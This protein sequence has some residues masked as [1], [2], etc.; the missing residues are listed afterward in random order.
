MYGPICW[1]WGYENGIG[2]TQNYFSLFFLGLLFF[3][4]IL[5]LSAT[6]WPAGLW[7]H[8]PH[9]VTNCSPTHFAAI[10]N[11]F[12]ICDIEHVDLE[13]HSKGSFFPE[14]ANFR[15]RHQHDLLIM[16]KKTIRI[17]TIFELCRVL[18][19]ISER[20]REV[21]EIQE[22]LNRLRMQTDK[23]KLSEFA[24]FCRLWDAREIVW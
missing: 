8:T 16:K 2:N 24:S 9:K 1:T 11:L 18:L 14:L 21:W 17:L 10:H 6:A 20:I 23:L 4:H 19:L 13:C 22:N 12:G 7:R 5:L 15:S 3:L